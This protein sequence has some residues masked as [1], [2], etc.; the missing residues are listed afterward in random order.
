[1]KA[2]PPSQRGY[3]LIDLLIG[4][5]VL[6]LLT[7][8]VSTTL[9]QS[10]GVQRAHTD[11]AAARN[12]LRKALGWFAEDVKMASNTGLVDGAPPIASASFTWTDKYGGASTTHTASYA[13]VSGRL[14][15]TYDA[16]THT[17]AYDVASLSFSRS[18]SAL[19]LQLEVNAAQGATET[20]SLTAVMR[21]PQ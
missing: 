2:W 19:T 17:V 7:I 12:E 21:V 10:V 8:G 16:S 11:V 14:I 20:E 5:A 4:L 13:L 9:F 3:L 6:G 15:R 18:A 1:M